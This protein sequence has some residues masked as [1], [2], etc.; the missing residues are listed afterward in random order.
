MVAIK[1][2]AY[3]YSSLVLVL[4]FVLDIPFPA[5]IWHS[6]FSYVNSLIEVSRNN[7]NAIISHKNTTISMM[8][9]NWDIRH[10]L[11]SN[12]LLNL[13]ITQFD[14]AVSVRSALS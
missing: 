9:K 3:L 4:P 11:E 1:P 8:S 12:L 10:Y 6:F 7:E 2:P 14:L 13:L 5:I